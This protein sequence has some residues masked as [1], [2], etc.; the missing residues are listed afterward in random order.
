MQQFKITMNSDF[1]DD[2][3]DSMD[4]SSALNLFMDAY[5]SNQLDSLSFSEEEFEYI[6]DNLIEQNIDEAVLLASKIAF[7]KYP[8]SSQFFIRYCDS[9]ILANEPSAALKLLDEYKGIFSNSGQILFLYA[10]AYLFLN[11]FDK[12]NEYYLLAVSEE[13]IDNQTRDSIYALAQ[14]C[15]EVQNFIQAIYYF[16]EIEARYG[17]TF[18]F[19]NDLAFCYDKMEYPEKSIECYNKYLDADPFNDNVWFNIGTVQARIKDFDKAIESFEYSIALNPANSSSLYN[20]GVVYMNLQRYKEASEV[21]E[22]FMKVDDDPLARFALS[23]SY[24]FLGLPDKAKMLLMRVLEEEPLS[25][26]EKNN[27]LQAIESLM[28]SYPVLANDSE[29][30]EFVKKFNKL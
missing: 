11:D 4:F 28:N 13:K 24:L 5:K 20:L 21:F 29:F 15:I 17:L 7:E 10:R 2:K 19:Y 23:E 25:A 26:E 14:D 16:K 27:R 3:D 9:L 22:S 8:Y 18:E 6:I 12:A 30:V 1:F